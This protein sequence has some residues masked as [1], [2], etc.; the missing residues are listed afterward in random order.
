MSYVTICLHCNRDLDQREETVSGVRCDGCGVFVEGHYYHGV[1]PGWLQLNIG[2][3]SEESFSDERRKELD[4]A[5]EFIPDVDYCP[6]CSLTIRNRLR[7]YPIPYSRADPNR[8][9]GETKSER[10]TDD[11]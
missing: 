7:D 1:P 9:D 8:P 6:D 10:G 3:E 11:G 4:G 5:E 2:E